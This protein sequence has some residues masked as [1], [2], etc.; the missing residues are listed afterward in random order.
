MSSLKEISV[1]RA[2]RIFQ[3]KLRSKPKT[4][5]CDCGVE[6][7][8]PDMVLYQCEL[9]TNYLS[10]ACDLCT[11][12]CVTCKQRWN[13]EFMIMCLGCKNRM[14][15]DGGVI[16]DCDRTSKVVGNY[17]LCKRCK[18]VRQPPTVK[19]SMC[20]CTTTSGVIQDSYILC[21]SCCSKCSPPYVK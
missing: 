12:E 2:K 3:G 7:D 9:N 16:D 15:Y 11:S 13:H 20:A 8:A 1:S 18:E 14:C 4:E 6:F 17:R 5:H 21:S 10:L 19:C